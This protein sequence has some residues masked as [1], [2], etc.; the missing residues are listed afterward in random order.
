VSTATA[1]PAAE[2][3]VARKGLRAGVIGVLGSTVLGIVQTA[4]AY[5]IAVT[6]GFLAAT[7][8]VHGPALLI[9]G[10]VPILCMTIVE[11]EFVARD[12]DCGTVF[13]WVG[14]ALGPRVGW[15]ASWALLGATLISLANLA[16]ITGTYFFLFV[17]ADSASTHE[18]ATIAVGCA[19][20]AVATWL[21]V[22][23]VQISARVQGVL[24][25]LGMAVLAVFVVVALVKVANGSA[26]RQAIDPSVS[27]LSP[28]HLGGGSAL[29]A[30]ILL[31]IFFFWGW[32][33]PAA[34]AE[35]ASGGTRTP[36][37]AL[38][39][40]AL[41]LLGFYVVVTVALQAYAGVGTKG[42]G[43]AN[44]DNSGDVLAVVGGAA[45]GSAFQTLME[46]AVL[47][48]AAACLVAAMLPTARS[49]L[50][51]G[52]YRAIPAAFAT[53]DARRHTP[54]A[55]TAAVGIGVAAVL[56][57]LS[58][59]SNNILGDSISALVLLIAFY[60]VLLGVAALT[61]FRHEIFTSGESLLRKGVAPLVGTLVLGWALYRN[62]RDT[63]DTDYGL[64]SLLGIGGVFVIGAATL[65]IGVVLMAVWNACSPA[66]FRGETFTEGYI[67]THRPDL[68]EELRV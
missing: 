42:I 64:T 13:V 43:L 18:A 22:R 11:Q 7:V 17:G 65:L 34:V 50:S 8:G 16:N 39:L 53:V 9:L 45:V 5:S 36:R 68:V 30:G 19:W 56:I 51:M 20:L 57:V 15:I 67:E 49:V 21:A 4:P 1:P 6:L 44:P 40:S 48:S 12:P 10:F 26:G 35:E 41:A 32:D 62:G 66:F 54:V 31:A 2:T 61:A 24:L 27:W 33:A 55:A 58:I 14:R 23:G 3:G 60:Y 28:F 59:V 52:A 47:T 25:S 63:F 37:R 38:M 29:S 46:L